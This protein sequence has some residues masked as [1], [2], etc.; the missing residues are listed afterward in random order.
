MASHTRVYGTERAAKI[1][2][3]IAVIVRQPVRLQVIVAAT[4]L[5]PFIDS[6]PQVVALLRHTRAQMELSLSAG[7]GHPSP[8]ARALQEALVA[9]VQ[10]N[11][12]ADIQ[13]QVRGEL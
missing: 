7:Y 4:I 2:V 11:A 5:Q 9:L 1:H 13:L 12:E 10:A 6:E 8:Q 3:H